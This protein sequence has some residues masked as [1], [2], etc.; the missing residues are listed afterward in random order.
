MT[1]PAPATEDQFRMAMGRFPT[2]VTA[3]TTVAG[4]QHHAMTANAVTSVSMDPLLVLA[5][6]ECEARFHDAIVESGVWGISILAAAQRPVADW[7]AT[8]GRPLHGQLDR[9]PHTLGPR[10]GVALIEGALATIECQ[11]TAI[12]PGGDHSIVLGEVV[13]VSVAEHPDD[14]LTYYRS[15]YGTLA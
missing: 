14:A 13:S 12:H 2:G 9:I 11:T 4:G 15:R 7:L 8:R 10:T 5:C 1:G 6:V 3:L